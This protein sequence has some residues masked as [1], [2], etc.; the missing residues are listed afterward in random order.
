M[1][2]ATTTNKQRY[3]VVYKTKW[4]GLSY[5]FYIQFIFMKHYSFVTVWKVNAPLQLIWNTIED[6]EQWPQWWKGVQSVKK[7][8]AGNPDGVGA[9]NE[10]NWKSVLPYQ[11]KITTKVTAI[12]KYQSIEVD[13]FGELA[14][15]GK[16]IFTAIDKN[17]THVEYYWN[18][19]TTKAWMNL[20]TPISFIFKWNHNVVMSWGGKGLGKL[21]NCN[22]EM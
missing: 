20:L 9:I 14:G 18:V 10:V 7:I 22:V 15:Q 5:L 19:K 13:A 17:C 11:L 2:A 16:W 3:K 21:L 1:S 6:V 12:L 8:S 4:K